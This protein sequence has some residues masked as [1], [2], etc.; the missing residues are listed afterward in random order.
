MRAHEW[1]LAAGEDSAN[2]P[3]PDYNNDDDAI[4]MSNRETN[5]KLRGVM[6]SAVYPAE[7]VERMVSVAFRR[8]AEAS[9][10]WGGASGSDAFELKPRLQET[11]R[12]W[13]AGYWR[14]CAAA[15]LAR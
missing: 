8:F 3:R 6:G 11:V 2:P 12:V 10:K 13:L 15:C 5:K 1:Q 9:A 14:V 7:A 4:V